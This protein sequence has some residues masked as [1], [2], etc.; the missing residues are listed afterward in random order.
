MIVSAVAHDLRRPRW[1]D[2]DEFPSGSAPLRPDE[3]QPSVPGRIAT[4]GSAASLVALRV[5]AG[6]GQRLRARASG[7]ALRDP[8]DGAAAGGT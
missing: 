3:R 4:D 6:A 5:P 2:A 1:V 8:A 7:P